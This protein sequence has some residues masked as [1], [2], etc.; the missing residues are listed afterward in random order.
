MTLLKRGIDEKD[1]T[2]EKDHQDNFFQFDSFPS[3]R[4][5]PW[6]LHVTCHHIAVLLVRSLSKISVVRGKG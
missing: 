2:V 3:I 1:G 5:W 6:R 4:W